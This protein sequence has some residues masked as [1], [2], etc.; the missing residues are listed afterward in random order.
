MTIQTM[1]RSQVS[2]GRLSI[3]H[4]QARIARLGSHG[5]PGALN[6]RSRSGR[7]RR[8]MITPADTTTKANSVPMLTISDSFSRLTNAASAAITAAV[9]M[10]ITYG[11]PKV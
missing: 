9:M 10:V 4:T 8:R 7:V 5:T 11:V 2:T 3:S 6:D 1:N